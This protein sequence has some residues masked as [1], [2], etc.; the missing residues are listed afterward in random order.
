[1][2]NHILSIS[3]IYEGEPRAAKISYNEYKMA[4]Q[5]QKQL[6]QLAYSR[7]AYRGK[8][9]VITNKQIIAKKTGKAAVHVLEKL[10]AKDPQRRPIITYIP[11]AGALIL[12]L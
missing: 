1:M 8:H 5:S 6:V 12:F 4:K 11:K 7:A 3:P 9:V 2:G 10:L